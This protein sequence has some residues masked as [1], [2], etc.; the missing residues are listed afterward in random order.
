M[1]FEMPSCGACRTC[2]MACSFHHTLEFNPACSSLKIL[3]KPGG[4][5]FLVDLLEESGDG[6]QA[7]DGCLGL[8]IPLCMQYC[9]QIDDLK[10]IIDIFLARRTLTERIID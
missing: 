6:R 9:C 7:C 4:D 5:G 3:E 8:D 10:N 2:E 1:I